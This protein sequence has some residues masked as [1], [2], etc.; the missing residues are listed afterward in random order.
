MEKFKQVSKEGYTLYVN[1]GG[2]T[3]GV[4]PEGHILIQD[5][6][7]FKDLNRNGTLDPY[8]DWRLPLETRIADLAGRLTKEE[9][10]GLMLY[11]AHQTICKGN[12]MAALMYPGKTIEDTREHI[13]SLTEMQKKFLKDDN[14]RHVLIAMVEDTPTAA[15]WNNQ[16]Q[17]FAEGIGLGIPVNISSDPRHTPAA[18]AEFDMGA[19]GDVSKW[20]D[21][22][23]LAATF[24]PDTVQR[25]GEAA[26]KEYRAM[27]ITTALSPQIDLATDPRWFRLTG[28]FGEGVRI[29]IDMA[30]AYCDGFQ[31]SAGDREIK[32]GWG[33]DS[34]NAMAKHWP[35]G[36]SGEAG[37]DAHF[38]S[39]KYAVYPGNNFAEHLR[40]FLEGALKL[41]GKTGAASAIMPYYTISWGIDTKYNENVG[42]SYS[43]YIITDL[44]RN[45][46][47][48]DGVV[49]T[50]WGIT[51][52]PS[53][54]LDTF[55]G[56]KS[57][58]V[59]TLT[60]AERHYK[61]L[62]AGVDQ[63]GG[64][65]D[66]EPVLEA[67][68]MGVKEHGEAYMKERFALSARRLLRNIFRTGLFENPYLDSGESQRIAGNAEF[69]KQGYDAQLHSIVLLKNQ[70][71]ALPLKS[72]AKV[73]IPQRHIAAHKNW[74]GMPIPE[75][76]VVPVRPELVGE[77]FEQVTD[78]ASADVALCFIESPKSDGY[79]EGQGYVP[80]NLQY[81]P[82]RAD[83]AREHN[84]AGTDDRSYRGKTGT[85]DNESDLDLILDTRKKMGSKP[86]L[87]LVKTQNPFVASEF[88]AAADAILLDFSVEARALLDIVSGKAEPSALLPFQMPRDMETVDA[89]LEDVPR[90]MT[91]YTDN[92]GNT[93]DFGFGLNWQGVIND[94]RVRKYT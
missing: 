38:G 66:A 4:G 73:Y 55:L 71:A 61:L 86:V 85:T 56:G 25:F 7:A 77:Y 8:E 45:K 72:K 30:R 90:D 10:A 11:S 44:L 60:T 31:T 79:R 48:Y 46:Y 40:P 94:D 34:V 70:N 74:F 88:E 26:S 12:P 65:N 75:R 5:G 91:P 89:Q 9:A 13:W 23:G 78:P 36:G 83:K 64:N 15:K 43:K 18:N 22:I 37:R 63:F 17:A 3:L 6:Y 29:A 69:V 57:W 93:W 39:G 58:G 33:Y 42:N 41:E 28:T 20:P 68:R 62:E 27:G 51:S 81:R 84:I 76:D 24:D 32:D 50:D 14:V 53:P 16:A 82:Y 2:P 1:E 67:Y 49:C 59:E 35:G 54:R 47:G 21:H 87:V 80:F 92:S 52:D 19:G